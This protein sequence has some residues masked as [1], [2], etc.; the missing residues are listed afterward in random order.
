MHDLSQ[1][2]RLANDKLVSHLAPCG[3]SSIKF[4][5]GLWAHNKLK[6]TFTLV[7][8]DFGVKHLSI[9]DILHLKQ[10]LETKYTIIIN[11]SGSLYIG[12]SLN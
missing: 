8:D 4:T 12:V 11:Y 7:V 3:Y 10:A 1:A 6:T 2:G 5:P 9:Q